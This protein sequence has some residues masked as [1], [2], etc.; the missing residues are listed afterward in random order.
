MTKAEWVAS[1]RDEEGRHRGKG[2]EA[3]AQRCAGVVAALEADPGDAPPDDATG[4]WL[5]GWEVGVEIRDSGIE[6]GERQP[7]F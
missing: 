6:M 1:F 3:K 2:R 4:D 5:D 7:M